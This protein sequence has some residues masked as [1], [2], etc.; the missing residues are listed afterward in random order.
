[1][2]IMVAS[3]RPTR[4]R[5]PVGDTGVSTL[6]E[7]GDAGSAKAMLEYATVTRKELVAVW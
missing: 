2:T 4:R 1:M 6:G 7:V 5:S 3:N